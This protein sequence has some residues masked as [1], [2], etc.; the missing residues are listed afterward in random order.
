MTSLFAIFCTLTLALP[1]VVLGASSNEQR[2]QVTPEK[3]GTNVTCSVSTLLMP[4]KVGPV[5]LY[6]QVCEN[7]ECSYERKITANEYTVAQRES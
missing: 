4:I 2:V 3:P 1:L 7:K 6:I 5:K